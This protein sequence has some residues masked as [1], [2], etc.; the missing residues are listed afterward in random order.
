MEIAWILTGLF[1]FVAIV[2]G[3]LVVM[4]PEWVGIQG[5]MARKIEESH[6]HDKSENENGGDHS[7]ESKS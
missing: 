2:F 5:K 4:A 1:I 3:A 6:R 7:T